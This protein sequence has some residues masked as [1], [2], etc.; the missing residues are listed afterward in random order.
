MSART[1]SCSSTRDGEPCIRE[2]PH[3]ETDQHRGTSERRWYY[4]DDMQR[5]MPRRYIYD[6]LPV[7]D[8]I[9]DECHKE[10]AC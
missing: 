3:R 8:L 6:H 2:T 10:M 9:I 5:G 1:F 7:I 4:G